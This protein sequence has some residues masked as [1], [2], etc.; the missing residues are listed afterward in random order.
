MLRFYVI[1]M[2]FFYLSSCIDLVDN[3]ANVIHRSPILAITKSKGMYSRFQNIISSSIVC[4]WEP[5]HDTLAR[6]AMYDCLPAAG[7]M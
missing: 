5:N 7:S 2:V 1:K 3:R 6:P 4:F